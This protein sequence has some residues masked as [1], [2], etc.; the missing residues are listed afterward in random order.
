MGFAT[1]NC[2]RIVIFWNTPLKPNQMST[3]LNNNLSPQSRAWIYQSSRRFTDAE[4]IIITD[5][6]KG[7]VN[8]WTAHKE[9]VTG[10]GLLFYNRF[11]VLLADE[12]QVG[13]SGCSVDSSVHFI[14]N[15]GQDFRT[16]FFDRWLIAYKL[17]DEVHTTPRAEFEKLVTSGKV[18][19][20]TIVFNNL[21]QTKAELEAKWQVPF[22]DSW[23]KNLSAAHTSFNSIL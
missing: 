8:Q 17:N 5:K 16:N 15:I 19:D 22:K 23:L 1:D 13:V 11:I 3:A 14:R 2:H 21:V 9:E 10:E 7:F 6:I 12:S 18:T 20:E 4:A